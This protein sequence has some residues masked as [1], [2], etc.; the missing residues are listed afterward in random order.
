MDRTIIRPDQALG[1]VVGGFYQR[2]RRLETRNA[3]KSAVQRTSITINEY[4]SPLDTGWNTI[5]TLDLDPGGW[6]VYATG[7]HRV[8]LYDSPTIPDFW[9]SM[10]IRVQWDGQTETD[11]VGF[12]GVPGEAAAHASIIALANVSEEQTTVVLSSNNQTPNDP[13]GFYDL[14]RYSFAIQAFPT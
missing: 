5:L 4:V 11:G 3:W 10:S 14:Y 13:V 2:L 12:S 7:S 9:P 1:D 8:R 6:V